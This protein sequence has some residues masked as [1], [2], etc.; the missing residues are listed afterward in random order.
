MTQDQ[1]L[2]TLRTMAPRLRA[3]GIAHLFLFG[4]RARGSASPASDVDLCFDQDPAET[5]DA[6]R[7]EQVA[8]ELSAAL[9][10]PVDL[11]ERG[12]FLPRSRRMIDAEALQVY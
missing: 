8:A 6:L 7:Q 9:G 5:P 3:Q 2:T 1:L 12:S 10:A 11:I 4:S